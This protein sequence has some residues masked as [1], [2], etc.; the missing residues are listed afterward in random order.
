MEKVDVNSF[1]YFPRN[2]SG[3]YNSMINPFTRIVIYGS[4][5]YQ[6]ESN[7]GDSAYACKFAKMIEYWRQIWSTRT[8]GLT[9]PQFPFGFVQ[10]SVFLST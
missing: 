3:L 2:H 5:W 6:G 9:D 8:N 10:V 4:I 1:G 7:S